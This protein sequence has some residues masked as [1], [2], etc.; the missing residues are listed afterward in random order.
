MSILVVG[1]VAFDTIKTPFG[2]A[3]KVLGGSATYFSMAARIFSPVNLVAVVG[4]DFPSRYLD[5]FRKK[6]IDILGLKQAPGKT[7]YWEGEYGWDFS[8]PKTLT[9][10]LNVFADFN[11]KIPESYKKSRYVFL[12]NID[13]VLQEKVLAQIKRPQLVAS[14]TMNHWISSKPGQLLKLLKK[15]DIFFLNASEAKQ[16]TSEANLVKAGKKIL[17]SGPK[18]VVVKKGEHGVIMF[19]KNNIFTAPAYLLE[20]VYD[21]TGAGDS[22]AGAFIGYLAKSGKI[23]QAVLR[24]AVIYA[25]VVATFTV[26]AFSIDRLA[27]VTISQV[28]Q[29]LKKFKQYTAF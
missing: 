11:P 16:L 19:S 24:K 29:R 6:G 20:S 21:P 14:D 5:L 9:T 4:R 28:K 17:K 25:N 3:R 7:F 23:N 1:S 10:D 18:V 27:K 12:A 22:F 26:E 15:V 13:P 8:D 2:E